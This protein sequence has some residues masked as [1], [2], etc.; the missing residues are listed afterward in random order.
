MIYFEV[1]MQQAMYEMNLSCWNESTRMG[2]IKLEFF[3]PQERYGWGFWRLN[4][5]TKCTE[6]TFS[7][8]KLLNNVSPIDSA[9][10]VEKV[11]FDPYF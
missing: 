1:K 11:E 9:V 10:K 5:I 4:D 2:L 8:Y 6:D 3:K 7:V